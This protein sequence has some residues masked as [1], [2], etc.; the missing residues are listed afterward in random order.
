MKNSESGEWVHVNLPITTEQ[1]AALRAEARA[2]GMH[3]TQLI[4]EAV[5]QWMMRR[6]V[7]A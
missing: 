3:M 2:R 1:H 4:R 6:K 5:M 7:K